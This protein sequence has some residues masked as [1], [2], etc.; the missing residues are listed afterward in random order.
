[1]KTQAVFCDPADLTHW[2]KWVERHPDVLI[3]NQGN[4]VGKTWRAIRV[5]SRVHTVSQGFDEIVYLRGYE[6]IANVI[7]LIQEIMRTTSQNLEIG[8][9]NDGE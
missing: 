4:A 6:K 2:H 9:P 1:M 5:T 3:H 7:D 8:R